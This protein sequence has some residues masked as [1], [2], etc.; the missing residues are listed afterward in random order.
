MSDDTPYRPYHHN[1]DPTDIQTTP[2]DVARVEF[3]RRLNYFMNRKGWNQSELARQ[4]IPHTPAGKAPVTR[5]LVSKYIRA[6]VLPT[7]ANMQILVETLGVSRDALLPP[8]IVPDA[9]DTLP[10]VE[11]KEAG[12]GMVWLRV[13]QA[14]TWEKGLR[15]LQI[16]KGEA[17]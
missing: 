11:I 3:A 9:G 17:E 14:V 16:L 7:P 10:P 4:T 12:E 13:N 1:S 15:I 5:D 6:Q 2:K 8:H